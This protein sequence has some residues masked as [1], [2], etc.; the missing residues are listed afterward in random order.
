VV[1]G[2]VAAGITVR[3]GTL[4]AVADVSLDVAPA[5]IVA[6]LGASGSGKSSLL[7]AIAGLEPLAAGN[8]S[9]DGVDLTAVPVHRRG[10]V[11]MFQDGQLFPHLSVGGNVGYALHGL[12]APRRRERVAELLGRVGLD[13]YA[14]RPITALSGGEAQRVA[15]A[16]SLA[17]EPRLLM[18]DEPLSSLDAGLRERLTGE[19]GRA[20]RATGTP[21]VYVTHD[22]DEAFAIADRVAVL[23]AGRLLQ[24]DTPATLWT[25]PASREVAEFLGYGPFLEPPVAAALGRPEVPAGALLA[26]GP[27]ALVPD[28]SGV[29]VPVLATA[30]GRG[31]TFCDLSL[32]D[33]QVGTIRLKGIVEADGHATV[34]IDRTGCAIV[35]TDDRSGDTP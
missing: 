5:E 26:L 18:L 22:Q 27:D 19:L 11:V 2:L 33:G 7:R 12:A 29:R 15:L 9:W 28:P 13:G 35:P 16:R 32:P 24:V 3:F 8:V 17:A 6:V 30:H 31:E 20:L 23:S 1:N 34:G 10:F 14:A 21:A 4:T 25:H